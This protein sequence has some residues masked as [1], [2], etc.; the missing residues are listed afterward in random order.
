MLHLKKSGIVALLA[1]GSIG[2]ATAPAG[3]D[4]ARVAQAQREG[5]LVWYT[6]LLE[7]ASSPI[8]QAYMARYPGI[9]VQVVRAAAPINAKKIVDEHQTGAV[10]ADL[11]DGSSTA[12]LLMA[13]KLVQPYMSPSAKTIPAQFKDPDGYW[14]STVLY[15]MTLGYNPKL[16]KPADAPKTWQDLLAPQWQGKMAWSAELAPTSAQGLIGNV[17]LSMGQEAGMDY[18]RRLSSQRIANIQINPRKIVGMVAREEYPIGLQVMVHHTVMAQREGQ[19]VNWVRMEPLTATGNAIGIAKDA[20]HLA[21]AKLMVDF[22]LSEDGQ[23]LLKQADHIPSNSLV[24]S[25]FPE[26]ADVKVRFISPVLAAQYNDQWN[27][28]FRE[29]FTDVKK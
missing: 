8:R 22:I 11:F 26:L 10:K 24:D 18:L 13:Q 12:G 7:E 15:Y 1:L 3:V 2:C 28:V 4:T 17:L 27:T 16:I 20:P 23:K 6:T 14:T 21:A 29:L 19:A 25:G 9:D 5:K